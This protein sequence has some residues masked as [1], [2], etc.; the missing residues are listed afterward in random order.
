MPIAVVSGPAGVGKTALAVHWAHEMADR[1]ADGQLYVNLR[2][3]DPSA[4]SA[5]ASEVI[6]G[7]LTALGVP[8]DWIPTTIDAQAALFRSVSAGRKILI[9]GEDAQDAVQVRPL[10]PG[11]PSCHVVVTSRCELTELVAEYGAALVTL[12]PLPGRGLRAAEQKARPQPLSCDPGA[13]SNLIRECVGMP[14][15]L[16][17]ATSAVVRAALSLTHLGSDHSSGPPG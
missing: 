6:R 16:N 17:A 12:G 2:G 14:L 11:S 3:F 10:L 4:P 15:A 1:F 7:F 13:A 8:A 9:V 5:D